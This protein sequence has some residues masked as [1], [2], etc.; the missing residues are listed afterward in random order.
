M[1][2]GTTYVTLVDSTTH[3]LGE[4]GKKEEEAELC[5]GGAKKRVPVLTINLDK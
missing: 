5:V 4:D 2:D 1:Y 3:L